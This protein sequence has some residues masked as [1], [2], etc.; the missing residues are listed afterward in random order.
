MLQVFRPLS[1]ARKR[2][3]RG[4]KKKIREL[5][6]PR[7]Y[8]KRLNFDACLLFVCVFVCLQVIGMPPPARERREEADLL[9]P[10]RRY[11]SPAARG[12]TRR[13][14]W[15]RVGGRAT[16]PQTRHH[17][18]SPVPEVFFLYFSF[19]LCVLFELIVFFLLFVKCNESK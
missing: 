4:E 7:T 2:R 10:P 3:K 19:G 14:W 6:V 15:W 8:L 9:V 13:Q 12:S 5:K 11:C 1:P 16:S 18:S 17:C